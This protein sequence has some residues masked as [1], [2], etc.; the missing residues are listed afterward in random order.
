MTNCP[1]MDT[2][3]SMADFEVK[4]KLELDR[5]LKEC[6]P[7]QLADAMDSELSAFNQWFAGQG[8]E[9]LVKMERTILKTYLAWKLLH[10]E[11]CPAS[12]A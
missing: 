7:T 2:L 10:E 11:G 5:P 8:N 1:H 12:K 6:P 9:P 3:V 4:I